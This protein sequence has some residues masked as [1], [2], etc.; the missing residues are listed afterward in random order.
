MWWD[1]ESRTQNDV[2]KPKMGP[3]N[4]HRSKQQNEVIPQSVPLGGSWLFRSGTV[5]YHWGVNSSVQ[6]G[7]GRTGGACWPSWSLFLTK[8]K[9][10]I[11]L[12][13]L[14]QTGMSYL[15]AA[16]AEVLVITSVRTEIW[17]LYLHGNHTSSTHS[18]PW[19]GRSDYVRGQF[20]FPMVANKSRG[21]WRHLSIGVQG[22][23]GHL[24][25]E[26]TAGHLGPPLI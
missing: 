15:R 2:V 13:E 20:S 26:R 10:D 14:T 7:V 21:Q 1:P 18:R 9:A 23:P 8:S 25:D 5:V 24:T 17:R 16:R 4:K 19:Q 22:R 12:Q 6:M 11:T 3:P